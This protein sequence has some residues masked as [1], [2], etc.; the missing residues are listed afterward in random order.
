MRTLRGL[1][2]QS[3]FQLY[4]P[5]ARLLHQRMDALRHVYRAKVLHGA[6]HREGEQ[7]KLD[8]PTGTPTLGR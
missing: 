7:P 2:S 1:G 4:H 8:L 6:R 5:H 3:P